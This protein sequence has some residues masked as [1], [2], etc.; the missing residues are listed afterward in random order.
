MINLVKNELIKIFSKKGI[1]IVLIIFLGLLA[2]VLG[3]QKFSENMS[4]ASYSAMIEDIEEIEMTTDEEKVKYWTL[5]TDQEIHELAQKY[6]GYKTWQGEMI[7]SEIWPIKTDLNLYQNGLGQYASFTTYTKEEL[8]NEYNKIMGRIE[9]GD[10]KSFVQE[11]LKELEEEIAIINEQL[12]NSE[13]SEVI[14]ELSKTKEILEIQT[15]CEKWRL[16]KEIP[17]R[18]ENYDNTLTRYSICGNIIAEYNYRYNINK[19]NYKESSSKE[20]DHYT[21]IEYQNA[22]E[23][24]EISK[25]RIENDI[26]NLEYES[27]SGALETFISDI[28]LLFI[29]IISIMVTGAIV[30]DE[31]NKGTIKL[32]LIR[33]YTRRKIM[34]SKIIASVIS[35]IIAIICMVLIQIIISGIGY[36]FDTINMP[37]LKYNFNTNSVMEINAFVWVIINLLTVSPII[38]IL[39]TLALTI[40]TVFTNSTSAITLSI[41][42]YMGSNILK[43]IATY[44]TKIKW[45]KFIPFVNWD[46][47]ECL[48]GKLSPIQGVTMQNAILTCSILIIALLIITFENFARKNIKNI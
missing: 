38:I 6:G 5:K 37:V 14:K 17:Y 18:D 36:G 1:Y 27:I 12:K 16:E 9:K 29:I 48:Y 39:A 7:L 44:E 4:V 23:E 10:W 19:N 41:L 45:L 30:S 11:D 42:V 22:L 32:L 28:G 47:T 24:F 31:F 34:L 20:F 43:S 13:E 33:P 2:L 26:P 35:I 15:Q 46:L 8:E 25:Y 21:K 3:I 40:S